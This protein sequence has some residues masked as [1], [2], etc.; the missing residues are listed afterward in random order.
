VLGLAQLR[1][2]SARLRFAFGRSLPV[3]FG[4]PYRVVS[5]QQMIGSEPFPD[6][7]WMQRVLGD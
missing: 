2:H 6:V 7:P 5:R 4:L 3:G 1:W